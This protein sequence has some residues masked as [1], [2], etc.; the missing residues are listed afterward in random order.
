MRWSNRW[1]RLGLYGVV[2]IGAVAAASAATAL[3]LTPAVPPTLARGGEVGS[4]PVTMQE[5][6]DPRRVELVV[7]P[8]AEISLESPRAGKVTRWSCA[9]GSTLVSGRSYAAIDGESLVN[10]ST[11]IPLWRDL[12]TGDRGDDVVALQTELQR[13][14]FDVQ[15]D[16]VLGSASITAFTR[17]LGDDDRGAQSIGVDRIVWQPA[18]EVQSTGCETRLGVAIGLGDPLVGIAS[19]PVAARVA[20]LPTDALPGARSLRVDGV[21]VEIDDSGA[22]ADAAARAELASTGSYRAALAESSEPSIA[23]TVSLSTPTRIAVVPPGSVYA[24]DGTDGCV[25]GD[26]RPTAIRVVGSQLGQTF[27]TFTE[28]GEPPAEVALH[29]DEDASCR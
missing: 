24:L 17:L 1:A 14:G 5:F 2:L 20:S 29:P 12:A 21:V 4:V 23:G 15:A 10:L 11:S 8:G 27:V 25:I 18:P 13:L 16:G 9:Q 26:G 22:V 6:D 7:T 28:A 19:P 3:V